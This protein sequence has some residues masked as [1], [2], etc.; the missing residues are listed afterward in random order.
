MSLWA[1]SH[2]V[3][4]RDFQTPQLSR[5]G[6]T[7]G[8]RGRFQI[9]PKEPPRE[10]TCSLG[11]WLDNALRFCTGMNSNW[12]ELKP[13]WHFLELMQ[14]QKTGRVHHMNRLYCRITCHF[15]APLKLGGYA[16][17]KDTPSLYMYICLSTFIS[18]ITFK[19]INVTVYLHICVSPS[20]HDMSIFILKATE[21]RW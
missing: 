6:A 13:E 8:T 14:T 9:P 7:G 5:Q 17:C 11:H 12:D 18:Y 16:K 1:H 2:S 21:D 15:E 19:L 3:E 4:R 10:C 20:T